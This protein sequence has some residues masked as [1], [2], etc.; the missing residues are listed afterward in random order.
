S[1]DALEQILCTAEYAGSFLNTQPYGEP[2]LSK[3]D[4]YPSVNA[5]KTWDNSTDN[6]INDDRKLLDAVLRILNYSDGKHPMVD[7]ASDHQYALNE[8]IPIIKMLQ[9]K[10]L[11][12]RNH[13]G[14]R[15]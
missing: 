8:M 1:A 11:L 9:N 3:H 14:E 13:K 5:P 6:I 15:I 7:I 12:R 4:L 2:M 10:S